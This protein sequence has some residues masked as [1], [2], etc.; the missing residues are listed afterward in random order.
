[1]KRSKVLIIATLVI[2]GAAAMVSRVGQPI[3]AAAKA[4]APAIFAWNQSTSPLKWLLDLE[5]R[6]N[7]TDEQQTQIKE[8]FRSH[9]ADLLAQATDEKSTRLALIDSIRNP[10]VN[11]AAIRAA[12]ANVAAVDSDLAV[13]RAQIYA[14]AYAVL[15]D[16]QRAALTQYMAETQAKILR[17]IQ[18]FV[19]N[20]DFSAMGFDRL[21]LSAGQK[22]AIK[23]VF[24]G[25]RKDLRSLGTAEK[26][27]RLAML[28]AI[29]QPAV[30][31]SGVRNAAAKVASLDADAAVQRAQIYSEVSALLDDTQRAELD[32]ILSEN[33][34]KVIDRI[35]F[36]IRMLQL[37]L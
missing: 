1:M 16:A 36:A 18:A 2:L 15:T 20:P 19:N 31:A 14:A 10:A 13:E 3:M 17:D 30:D 37:L 12:S 26:K 8:I 27:A 9:K 22:A 23:A 32:N 34:Q 5:A 29:R 4:G 28:A 35:E 25:H 24:E 33:T 6:L 11:T 21:N 7:L